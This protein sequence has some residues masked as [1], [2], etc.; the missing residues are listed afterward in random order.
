MLGHLLDLVTTYVLSPDLERESNVMVDRFGFGW[1]YILTMA[2]VSSLVM[3]AVLSWMWPR[4]LARFPDA[5]CS[6]GR[7]YRRVL[8]GAGPGQAGD[9]KRFTTGALIGVI[10]IAAYAAIATKLLTGV[11]NLCVL[12]FGVT[13]NYFFLLVAAKVVLAAGTGLVM[14]FWYP[15]RLHRGLRGA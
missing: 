11:W 12:A 7:F 3:L 6:Y 1:G 8:Y 2:A 10:C 9:R 14:F 15:Y 4:L 13:T 5:E